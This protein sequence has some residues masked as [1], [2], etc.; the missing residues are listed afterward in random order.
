MHKAIGRAQYEAYD[1][2]HPNR[3]SFATVTM[4]LSLFT[5]FS[6]RLIRSFAERTVPITFEAG[7]LFKC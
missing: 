5:N 6:A 7:E 2:A 4:Q 3:K 1:D